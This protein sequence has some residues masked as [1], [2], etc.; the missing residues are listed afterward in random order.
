VD[1]TDHALTSERLGAPSRHS[2]HGGCFRWAVSEPPTRAHPRPPWRASP[3]YRKPIAQGALVAGL[4]AGG[5][6]PAVTGRHTSR[7]HSSSST[8]ADGWARR[9]LGLDRTAEVTRA[10]AAAPGSMAVGFPTGAW[11]QRG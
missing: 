11:Q 8:M 2:R 3:V 7:W 9:I 6:P 10:A 1:P 5:P 4:E